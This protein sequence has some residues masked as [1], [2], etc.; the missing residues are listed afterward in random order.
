MLHKVT[1]EVTLLELLDLDV[2]PR[3]NILIGD[4]LCLNNKEYP[5]IDITVRRYADPSLLLDMCH[6]YLDGVR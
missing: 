5:I 6:N 2:I 1:V 3:Y 4:R